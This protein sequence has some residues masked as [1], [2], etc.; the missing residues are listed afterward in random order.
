MGEGDAAKS[1][2]ARVC[3]AA[4]VCQTAR[5]CKTTDQGWFNRRSYH[6]VQTLRDCTTKSEAAIQQLAPRLL[7]AAASGKDLKLMQSVR[8]L[9]A[10]S[11]PP[12]S[13]DEAESFHD[14]DSQAEADVDSRDHPPLPAAA[15]GAK[16]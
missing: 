15:Q 10:A 2:T 3:P 9:E 16:S 14:E 7:E 4:G 1:S 13:Y 8:G 12:R 5:V 6:E 11:N